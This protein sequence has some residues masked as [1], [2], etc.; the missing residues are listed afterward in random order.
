[1]IKTKGSTYCKWNINSP[2]GSLT[3]PRMIGGWSNDYRGD[4]LGIL[5]LE[6]AEFEP[7]LT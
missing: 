4:L 7:H 1:M 2:S 5:Y 6:A 3:K